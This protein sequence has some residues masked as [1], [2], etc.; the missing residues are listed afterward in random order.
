MTPRSRAARSI[1]RDRRRHNRDGYCARCMSLRMRRLLRDITDLTGMS[2]RDMLRAI[3][4]SPTC[5]TGRGFR[6]PKEII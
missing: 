3:G 5:A 1:L 6:I 4:G 2:Y